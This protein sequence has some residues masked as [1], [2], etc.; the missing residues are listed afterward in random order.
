VTNEPAPLAASPAG[1]SEARLAATL[2]EL[3]A[4]QR[5]R[6]EV[7]NLNEGLGLDASRA[8]GLD[9]DD[10]DPYCEHLI[11]VD[12]ATGR[13]DG[14]YRMLPW[15]RVPSCGYYAETEFDIDNVKRSFERILELG[16]S[17]VRPSARDG[18]T[19]DLLFRGLGAYVG[20]IGAEALVGCV[21]VPGR[22]LARLRSIW[23]QLAGAGLIAG[24]E[25]AVTPRRG[26]EVPGF[27]AP[28]PC[29]A[30]PAALPPLFAAYLRLGARVCG[31][32]AYDASF[33]TTDFFIVLDI[34]RLADGSARRYLAASADG[35]AVARAEAPAA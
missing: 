29:G 1:K 22:D 35:R 26:F 9:E 12:R 19:I 33:G 23:S 18:R 5:L 27:D 7:F 25:F 13:V 4:A 21:S 32:P 3:R 2:D 11:V 20:R 30:A 17:C 10:F 6:F 34:A 28:P 31:P 8:A 16:R 14:T 15:R 24:R